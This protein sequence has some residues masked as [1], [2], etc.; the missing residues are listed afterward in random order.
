[1][2]ETG[3]TGLEV[4]VEDPAA[5]VSRTFRVAVLPQEHRAEPVGD[6]PA[7]WRMELLR[8][9]TSGP[10]TVARAIARLGLEPDGKV[11]AQ[12]LEPALGLVEARGD[13]AD[14]E[15]VG[16]LQLWHR[17]AESQ[18]EPGLRDQVRRALTGFKYWID[19]P[20]LDAMCYFTENH[21]M[22]WHTAELLAGEALREE[23]FSNTGWTGA[24][25]AQHGREMALAWMRRKLAGGFSE[26]DSNAYLAIDSL[27]LV[28]LVDFAE[29]PAVGRL[30][31]ALL[32]KVLF[33]LAANSWRG[34]HGAAHGR[35]YTSTLRSSRFEETAPIMWALWGTGAL[36]NALLPAVALSES[37][38]YVLP[39]LVRAV[40]NRTGP[41]WEGRQ[42]YRGQYAFERD[43]LDRPYGSDLV[44]WRTPD[45]MLSSVQDYRAGLPG[46]QEHVWGATLG[47]ETQ[48]FAT[49][50][51]AASHDP[52]TRPNGWA[53]QRILPRVR[54]HGNSLLVLHTSPASD[55]FGTTHLWFPVPH[56]DEH[57]Q[58]GSWL[59]GRRGDGYVAVATAQGFAPTRTGADAWQEWLPFGSGEAYVVT[60]GSRETSGGFEEFVAGLAEPEFS[61]GATR[62]A[63]VRWE[64]PDGR[65]LELSWSGSF[66]V[67]G[68]DP[69]VPPEH[70]ANHLDNPACRLPFGATGLVA[71]WEGERLVLDLERGTRIE[72]QSGI[73]A[74]SSVDEA[75]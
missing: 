21:Q 57:T 62:G 16:M 22:V 43:L 75:R 27:A 55:P 42:V 47:P 11:S 15:A 73:A 49:H 20:G 30:A 33:T 6:D 23:R 38:R 53:G 52:S 12:D 31:E 24:Q 7:A 51:A 59:A 67:D 39:P 66:L 14:F 70:S 35:T 18:W 60:V 5:P 37:R 68:R 65:R 10:P 72:P 50:P 58:R 48:I 63:Q 19:Q 4:R 8:H 13:C 9:A 1:M 61:N 44:A 26:F 40:A 29:D 41:V 34:V 64:A 17:V 74:L 71:E 45:V 2:L 46:L 3:E 56:L 32:D 54:Q 28:S 36:N 25:H 69:D